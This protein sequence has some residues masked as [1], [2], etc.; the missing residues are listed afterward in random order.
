MIVEL[1]DE[2][3]CPMRIEASRVV[4]RDKATG[5]LLG[6]AIENSPGQYVAGAQPTSPLVATAAERGAFQKLQGLMKIRET[7]L[8]TSLTPDQLR[9]P[10]IG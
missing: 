5:T 2:C 8:V 6:L 10:T 4:I 9:V 7:T 3:G 1:I